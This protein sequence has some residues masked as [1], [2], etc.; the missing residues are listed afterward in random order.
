MPLILNATGVEPARRGL[1][2]GK[3]WMSAWTAF[4]KSPRA[5]PMPPQQT[6]ERDWVLSTPH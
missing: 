1:A 3:T 6:R 2:H 4:P 5:V